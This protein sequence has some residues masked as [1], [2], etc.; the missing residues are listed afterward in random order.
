MSAGRS[1]GVRP[2]LTPPRATTWGSPLAVSKYYHSVCHN[3]N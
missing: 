1:F 2:G 3:S